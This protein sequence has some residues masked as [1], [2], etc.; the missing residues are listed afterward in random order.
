VSARLCEP[1]PHANVNLTCVCVW[2]ACVS[3]ALADAEA[4]KKSLILENDGLRRC[5]VG[6]ALLVDS[7]CGP[8]TLTVLYA[9]PSASDCTPRSKLRGAVHH[10]Q[11]SPKAPRP[12]AMER[13]PLKSSSAAGNGACASQ[14]GCLRA[15]GVS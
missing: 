8:R 9:A 2:A 6:G 3:A 10:A 12:M 13:T 5:V 11:G 1:Q 7:R 14:H 4:T 15:L